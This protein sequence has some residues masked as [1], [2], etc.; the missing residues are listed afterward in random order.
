METPYN[1]KTE[2]K[3][4]ILKKLFISNFIISSCTFG[5]GFIIVSLMKDKFVDQYKWLEENEMLDI[6]AIAQSAPGPIPINASIIL[7]YKMAGLLGV[8]AGVLGTVL[9]PMIIISIISIF[10]AQFC[11]NKIIALALQVMRAGVAA[12]IIDVVI[13]LAKNVKS[14]GR[15]L[16]IILAFSALIA[17]ILFNINASLIILTCLLIGILDLSINLKKE[18]KS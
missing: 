15:K 1:C 7:G 6:T 16:Y 17:K 11:S 9:P 3:P 18:G 12:V 14:C 8:M 4:Q 13:N 10:Y 5:G 2:G